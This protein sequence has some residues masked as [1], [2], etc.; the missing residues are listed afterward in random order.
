MYHHI[1]S[2]V[3]PAARVSQS[4]ANVIF[5]PPFVSQRAFFTIAL[6]FLA[7]IPNLHQIIY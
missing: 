3:F 5:K 1:D 6:V 4:R 7:Y 2:A